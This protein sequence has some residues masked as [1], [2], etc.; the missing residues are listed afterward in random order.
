MNMDHLVILTQVG[1]AL[2]KMRRTKAVG[3]DNISIE[4]LRGLG[5]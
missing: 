5:V 3:A 4:V 2:K 1:K